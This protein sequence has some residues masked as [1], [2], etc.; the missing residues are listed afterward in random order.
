[1]GRQTQRKNT[2]EKKAGKKHKQSP[3][4]LRQVTQFRLEDAILEWQAQLAADTTYLA[5]LAEEK[6]RRQARV[7]AAAECRDARH[8]SIQVAVKRAGLI[9]HVRTGLATKTD[10]P[11]V[12]SRSLRKEKL[13]YGRRPSLAKGERAHFEFKSNRKTSFLKG[14]FPIVRGYTTN[15]FR[16]PQDVA[17]LLNTAGLT[18]A[19]G[20]KWTARLAWLLLSLLSNPKSLTRGGFDDRQS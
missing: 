18:T 4:H 11:L 16:Q 6:K 2:A 20:K 1:V 13:P 12:R 8:A 3:G 7:K 9:R 17:H 15:G 5:R 10:L 14:L 19:C